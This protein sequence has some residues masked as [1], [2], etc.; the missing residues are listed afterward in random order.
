MVP[1][2]ITPRRLGAAAVLYAVFVGGWYLGQPL[3][4]VG[5]ATSDVAATDDASIVGEP[6]DFSEDLYRP[7]GQLEQVVTTDILVTKAIATCEPGTAGRP[8]LVAWLIGD[9]R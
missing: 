8:R 4:H 1:T 9:W 7:I 2:W 3:P 6:G 5:C